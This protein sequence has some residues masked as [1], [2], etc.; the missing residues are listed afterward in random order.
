MLKVIL[1]SPVAVAFI[2]LALIFFI[3]TI[4]PEIRLFNNVKV[5]KKVVYTSSRIQTLKELI[6]KSSTLRKIHNRLTIKIGLIKLC[7]EKECEDIAVKY[8]VAYILEIVILMMLT[9]I[10]KT[11]NTLF[12]DI[13]CLA[14]PLLIF[15]TKIAISR[16]KLKDEFI[17]FIGVFTLKYSSTKSVK[18]AL[19]QTIPEVSENMR[20]HL[21]RLVNSM[22]TNA[23]REKAFTD[24]SD[25]MNYIMCSSFVAIINS[26]NTSSDNLLPSLLKLENQIINERTKERKLNQ[27]YSERKNELLFWVLINIAIYICYFYF[28]P[29]IANSFF[30]YSGLGQALLIGNVLYIIVVILILLVE[31]HIE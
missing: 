21:I 4:M 25:R 14:A 5:K 31:K 10:L 29:Q 9:L 28:S 7:S 6:L 11:I 15:N 20:V 22:N 2:V 24:F 16:S 1:D 18:D 13:M 12:I 17:N 3:S 23:S 19:S 8:I 27:K 30:I 26:A